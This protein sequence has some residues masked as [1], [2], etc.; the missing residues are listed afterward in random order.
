M[1]VFFNEEIFCLHWNNSRIEKC[2]DA[3]G[4]WK[5]Q[6]NR[7]PT[8]HIN[9]FIK[10]CF[11]NSFESWLLVKRLVDRCVLFLPTLP[12]TLVPQPPDHLLCQDISRFCRAWK[13]FIFSSISL[14]EVAII[15]KFLIVILYTKKRAHSFSLF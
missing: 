2:R 4:S 1:N 14:E 3:G 5:F 6:E 12:E 11:I 15:I 7:T 13:K 10:I 8:I 9:T